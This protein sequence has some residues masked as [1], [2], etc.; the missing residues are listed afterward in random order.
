MILQIHMIKR[1]IY[2]EQKI[3]SRGAI[4]RSWIIYHLQQND[5]YNFNAISSK[6]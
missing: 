1:M 2:E 3:C 5:D 6:T 4:D